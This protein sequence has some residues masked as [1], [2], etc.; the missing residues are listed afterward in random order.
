MPFVRKFVEEVKSIGLVSAAAQR[1][2]LRG[3]AKELK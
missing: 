2:G 3:T 1:A